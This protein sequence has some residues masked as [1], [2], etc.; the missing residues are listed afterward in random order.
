MQ[1]KILKPTDGAIETAAAILKENGLVA[2]PTETVYGL[3]A[4]AFSEI[5]IEKIFSAKDRPR[6]NPLIV[7]I[8]D[9]EMLGDLVREIPITA[10]ILI[11]KFWPGPLTLILPKT[12]KV[13]RGT[14]CGLD[15]VAV[16]FP[17]NKIAIN[18]IKKCGF[19]L[20]APSANSSGKP[21]PTKAKHVYDDLNGK[22]P[23]IIDGGE[24]KLGIES[25]VVLPGEKSIRILR[26]GGIT[27]E[28]ISEFVKVEV[29]EL[30]DIKLSGEEKPLS[31][32]LKYKHYSPRAK[33]ILV[34]AESPQIF[35]GY[36]KENYK[37]GDFA[38]VRDND[39]PPAADMSL[40][41][42]F[43]GS[44]AVEQAHNLFSCLRDCDS[45]EVSRIFIHA[46]EKNGLGQAVYNRLKRAAEITTCV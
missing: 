17:E 5:A 10:K 32:G 3:A 15:T 13:P 36:Y 43:Y 19:P 44:N 26:P 46:P 6:D 16:R 23:L 37:E 30:T 38:L 24:C 9:K 25:T 12:E 18:L 14:N 45:R 28:E 4:N 7:H 2:M 34:S 27:A 39:C 29:C 21:S 11:E 40:P 42:G 35:N 1:T 31:P 41:Y 20:A 8:A 22:I 33:L